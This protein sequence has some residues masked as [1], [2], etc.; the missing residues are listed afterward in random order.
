MKELIKQVN[1]IPKNTQDIINTR[2]LEFKSFQDKANEEWF[3]ELCFCILT[4]NSRAKTAINIQ[5][6]I[7]FEGF[8]KLSQPQRLYK[9]EL[10]GK[11]I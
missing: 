2:L 8:S 11:G 10:S 4:A 7:G 6:E 1:S 3:S 5:K 9:K